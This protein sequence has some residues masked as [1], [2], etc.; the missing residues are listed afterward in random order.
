MTWTQRYKQA[1]HEWAKNRSPAFFEASGGESMK[2]AYPKVTSTNGLT[3]AVINFLIWNGHHAER[4][5]T[6]GVMRDNRKAVTDCVG[7]TKMIGS[8]EW[9]KSA[10]T[11]GSA[12]IHAD[13]VH[14]DYK[15][16]IP[17]KI[18]I[19]YNKDTMRKA[20]ERY[21]D[22]IEGKKGV[23]VIVKEIDGFFEWYD[24]FLLSL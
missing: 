24:K 3:R 9:R 16:A 2:V 19:K 8:I 15:F 12:D 22:N 17:I 7:R 1:H 4:V 5:S 11:T 13:L 20:Q 18:E 10:S 23:Y 14:K 21:Q 6:M